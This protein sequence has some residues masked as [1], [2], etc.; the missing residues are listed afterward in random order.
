MTVT[1][2]NTELAPSSIAPPAAHYAHAIASDNATRWVHT[3]G[4]VP[5]APDGTTPEGVAAQAEVVWANVAAILAEAGL[6][7]HNIVSVATYVV[8]DQDM[9]AVMAAR[10]RYLDG[11]RVASTLV[12]VAALAQPQWLVEA[13]VVAC[14]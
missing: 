3:A 2:R 4:V 8:P 14:G 12:V 13:S 11:H 5:T 10:D 1:A 6:G 9:G 7:P